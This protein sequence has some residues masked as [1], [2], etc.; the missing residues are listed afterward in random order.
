MGEEKNTERFLDVLF[1]SDM[2]LGEDG[3][4]R[5]TS[6]ER[7]ESKSYRHSSRQY[8]G[9]LHHTN[10]ITENLLC[11]GEIPKAEL[12]AIMTIGSFD[13]RPKG[14]SSS[15]LSRR[16][17][18]TTAATSKMLK[19]LEDKGLIWRYPDEKDRRKVYITLSPQGYD[20]Y[21]E[22][23][24]AQDEFMSRVFSSFGAEDTER[25]LSLWQRFNRILEEENKVTTD[26]V[27]L[28]RENMKTVFIEDCDFSFTEKDILERLGMP[29][30][31]AFGEKIKEL[32]EV[33]AP[34]AKPKAF[35]ME[36]KI[37]DRTDKT[38]TLG[39]ETFTSVALAK[40]FEKVDTVYP[41]LCT[42]GR[43]L[44]E[45]SKGISDIM[46][47]YAFDVIMEFYRKRLN[48][49]L[50]EALANSLEDGGQTSAVNPGSLIDWPI[51]Q[52]R[53]L[54]RVFG[55]NAVKIG[56]ELTENYLMYPIKTVSGIL[57]P[58]D[59]KFHNCQLCQK[60]NCPSREA[61]F[62][63]ELYMETLHS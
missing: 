22:T 48:A 16:L 49:A 45:Y 2:M 39:G 26:I 18:V 42:C 63:M 35:Y 17:K 43:E 23:A 52:Q 51:H 44:A 60:K 13:Y 20:I 1:R 5:R 40:N 25:F 14:V 7:D 41:F 32:M 58:T 36:V 19:V 10:N 11:N 9:V 50:T 62:S 61:P 31:H 37:E 30:E 28:R 55:E 46:E 56:V 3:D 33:A 54:F 57:Y 29:R 27:K 8:L 24:A 12:N 6:R 38:V 53:K 21:R 34:L 15:E 59:K 4:K 47:G